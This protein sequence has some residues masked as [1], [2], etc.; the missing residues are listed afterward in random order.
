MK[1]AEPDSPVT[2]TLPAAGAWADATLAAAGQQSTLWTRSVT[3]VAGEGLYRIYSRVTDVVGNVTT[4][5]AS[6]FRGSFHADSTPFSG[7]T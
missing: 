7:R 1:V 5:P 6:L 2:S 3:P 4:N